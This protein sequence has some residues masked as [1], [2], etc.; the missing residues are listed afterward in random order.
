MRV[1]DL[2][3]ILEE[4]DDNAKVVVVDFCNGTTRDAVVGS[5]DD[6]EGDKYCR[7]SC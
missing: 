3:N 5:D 7:I 1:K 4:Y 6:D 2:K